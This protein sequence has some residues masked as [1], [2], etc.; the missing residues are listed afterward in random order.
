M[1]IAETYSFND[2][3]AVIARDFPKLLKDVYEVIGIIDAESCR[4]KDPKG[5]EQKRLARIGED[6][7]YSPI[8]LNALFDYFLMQRGWELKPRIYTQDE[9]REGF[10]EM[11]FINGKLGIEVQFGKYAFLTYDVIAKMVI[12]KN[13][14]L[15]DAGI[16]ICPMACMLPHMSSGIGAFEQVRWDLDKRGHVSGFDVPVLV[17]GVATE[18][19]LSQADH[20]KPIN[21]QTQLCFDSPH[22]TRGEPRIVRNRVAELKK[23]IIDKVRETGLDV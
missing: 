23:E 13:F 4:K 3:E 10:R 17:L 14:G 20:A 1:I 5:A 19:A 21:V 15:I 7:L 22:E 12:Y 16:E 2:G 18:K 9:S 8:Y 6:R 11:D